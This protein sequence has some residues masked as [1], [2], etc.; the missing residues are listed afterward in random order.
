MTE[1]RLNIEWQEHSHLNECYDDCDPEDVVKMLSER[2]PGIAF[3][4]DFYEIGA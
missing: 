2:F 1:I 3:R 4:V